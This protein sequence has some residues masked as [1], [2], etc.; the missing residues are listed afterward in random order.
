MPLIESKTTRIIIAST[1][2]VLLLG[3]ELLSSPR[4]WPHIAAIIL[5]L[6]TIRYV[7]DWNPIPP[8]QKVWWLLYSLPI[9]VIEFSYNSKDLTLLI[10]ASGIWLVAAYR[11]QQ[12]FASK[13]LRPM[14]N[15]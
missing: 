15:H 11:L 6:N 8:K 1:V 10:F 3:M 2:G 5:Y 14:A 9:L 13:K 4:N 12:E 7:I